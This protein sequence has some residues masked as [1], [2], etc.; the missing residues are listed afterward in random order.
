ME[1]EVL[2]N[3][4]LYV[5]LGLILC[6][7]LGLYRLLY[8][9]YLSSGSFICGILCLV[10]FIALL[11][12]FIFGDFGG[13]E[14][15]E[16]KVALST[17]RCKYCDVIIGMN[18]RYCKPCVTRIYGNGT[19]K[20]R[21]NNIPH[22]RSINKPKTELN[23][24]K[25]RGCNVKIGM[26]KRYCKSCRREVD[27]E[28]NRSH[29]RDSTNPLNPAPHHY[30]QKTFEKQLNTHKCRGCDVQIGMNKRHCKSCRRAYGNRTIKTRTD[31]ILHSQAINKPQT[32]QDNSTNQDER[33]IGVIG[34]AARVILLPVAIIGAIFFLGSSDYKK[35]DFP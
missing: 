17:T 4:G 6:V 15:K 30:R 27:L 12:W 33:T 29:S 14:A 25:C 3:E 23:T 9:D 18:K 21:T 11:L 31:N 22:S 8:L 32:K 10:P 28:Q 5:L 19:S 16:N 7:A 1:D 34:F 24:R 26:N 20:T 13:S 35:G 2:G